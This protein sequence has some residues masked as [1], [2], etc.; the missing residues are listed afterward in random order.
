VSEIELIIEQSIALIFG[1]GC[2]GRGRAAV[3]VSGSLLRFCVGLAESMTVPY[4]KALKRG[5]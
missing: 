4:I 2:L 1:K 3:E 5:K